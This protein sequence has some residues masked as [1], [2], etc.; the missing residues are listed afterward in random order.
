M[1]A[2][3]EEGIGIL[4]QGEDNSTEQIDVHYCGIKR[5]EP[6]ADKHGHCRTDSASSLLTWVAAILLFMLC[7]LFI[8]LCVKM[9]KRDE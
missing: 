9:D 3:G 5:H 2:V 8:F 4:L 7:Y 6:I 1:I